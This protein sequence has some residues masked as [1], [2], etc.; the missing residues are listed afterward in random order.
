MS[1][2]KKLSAGLSLTGLIGSDDIDMQR[3]GNRKKKYQFLD[4]TF[5]WIDAMINFIFKRESNNVNE[6]LKVTWGPLFFGLVVIFIF[7][8]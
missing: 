7:L 8:E 5:A 1:K 3:A 2:L 6:V 4:K